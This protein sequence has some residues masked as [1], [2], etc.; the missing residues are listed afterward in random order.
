MQF[1]NLAATNLSS[2]FLVV[3]V[4]EWNRR[5]AYL[6]QSSPADEYGFMDRRHR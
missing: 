6:L 2:S 4:L 1:S 3:L 5:G